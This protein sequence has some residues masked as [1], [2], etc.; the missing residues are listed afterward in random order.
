MFHCALALPADE[1]STSVRVVSQENLADR[2]MWQGRTADAVESLREALRM[3]EDQGNESAIAKL[4]AR[5][6]A[7]AFAEEGG[8]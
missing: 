1:V 3:R 8:R 5:I 4:R 2:Y 7:A 6:A